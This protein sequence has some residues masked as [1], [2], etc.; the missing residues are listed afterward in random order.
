M[1]KVEKNTDTPQEWRPTR[2]PWIISIPLMASVFMFA[3]D[4]TISNVALPYMAGSFS[5]SHSEATWVITFYLIASGII[6][7]AVDFF[8][9][10][11]GRKNFFLLSI[12]VFTIS[13]FLCGISMI[14]RG[15]GCLLATLITAALIGKFGEKRFVLVG[16]IILGIGGLAFGGINLQI[17]LANIGFPNFLFGLGMVMAMVPLIDMSCRT[18]RNDQLTNASGIQNLIKNVGAAIG[19]SLVTTCV[20]RFAQTH[21]YMMV[22]KLSE[23]NPAFVERFNTYAAMFMQ[24]MDPASASEKAA[25]LLYNQLMQQSALWAYIDTFRIFAIAAFMIIPLLLFL[26]KKRKFIN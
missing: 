5:C 7:P 19:T 24:S 13:S 8:C 3:L 23:L 14:P 22:G 21:Q 18:L 9:K 16:L 12:I 1:G 2:N 15:G 17:S 20:S 4:E 11:L 6:I 26:N 10:L 25:G